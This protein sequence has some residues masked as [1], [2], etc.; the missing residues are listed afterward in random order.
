MA[1]V[2]GDEVGDTPYERRPYTGPVDGG[3][4]QAATFSECPTGGFNPIANYMDYAKDRCMN[5]WTPGQDLRARSLMQRFRGEFVERSPDLRD[6]LNM[7]RAWTQ[8]PPRIAGS[9]QPA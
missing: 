5:E 8:T 3:A 4:R 2:P 6:F 1:V 9:P 7:R